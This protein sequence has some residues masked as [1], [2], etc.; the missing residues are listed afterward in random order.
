MKGL[1]LRKDTEK[2]QTQISA[3][4]RTQSIVLI[5]EKGRTR[6]RLEVGDDRPVL[7]LTDENGTA[8]VTL[9]VDKDRPVLRF[10]DEN[11]MGDAMLIAQKDGPGHTEMRDKVTFSTGAPFS[12]NITDC[13]GGQIIWNMV[14]GYDSEGKPVTH[15]FRHRCSEI[16]S[17]AFGVPNA[18]LEKKILKLALSIG[19]G[20]LAYNIAWNS[21]RNNDPSMKVV[22]DDPHLPQAIADLQA[23][24]NIYL[25][26][27]TRASDAEARLAHLQDS[28]SQKELGDI[29]AQRDAAMTTYKKAQEALDAICKDILQKAFPDIAP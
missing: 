4:V 22:S 12:V 7:R 9:E 6:V 18:N 11:D 19:N 26:V 8:S 21:N 16:S 25:A 20:V 29:R 13:R 10:E 23:A 17:I 14:T 5:D 1:R 24:R 27:Q 2:V 28:R 15:Q 3:E